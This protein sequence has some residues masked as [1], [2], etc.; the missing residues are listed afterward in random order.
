MLRNIW[1]R[2]INRKAEA[3]AYGQIWKDHY[4]RIQEIE[5]RESFVYGVITGVV[6]TALFLL[7]VSYVF[8]VTSC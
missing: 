4:E 1:N 5:K 7:I 3:N 2:H 8:S 6:A